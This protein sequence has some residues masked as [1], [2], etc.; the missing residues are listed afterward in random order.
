MREPVGARIWEFE[1]EKEVLQ[2]GGPRGR[3]GLRQGGGWLK[4]GN[5]E[6]PLVSLTMEFKKR[7][8]WS[9]KKGSQVQGRSEDFFVGGRSW[10]KR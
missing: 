5:G 7:G 3:R 4:R 10:A 8:K 6:S 9:V 1:Q 2:R